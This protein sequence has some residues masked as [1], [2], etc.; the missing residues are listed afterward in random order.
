MVSNAGN[1][2]IAE[3]EVGLHV[4]TLQLSAYEPYESNICFTRNALKLVYGNQGTNIFPVDKP[5]DPRS[6]ERPRVMRPVEGHSLFSS[7]FK[8]TR[9]RYN[10]K[11]LETA[12]SADAYLNLKCSMRMSLWTAIV[13]LLV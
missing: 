7:L 3:N 2:L 6:Q 4:I 11:I 10:I 8:L 13:N 5:H 1:L 12:L 9:I